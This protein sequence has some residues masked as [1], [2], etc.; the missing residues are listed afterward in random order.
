MFSPC[1]GDDH[2]TESNRPIEWGLAPEVS[3][4]ELISEESDD[5]ASL[6]REE[7]EQRAAVVHSDLLAVQRDIAAVIWSLQSQGQRVEF[8][9]DLDPR[10]VLGVTLVFAPPSQRGPAQSMPTTSRGRGG[11]EFR[12]PGAAST[13]PAHEGAEGTV[14]IPAFRA[15]PTPTAPTSHAGRRAGRG[16]FSPA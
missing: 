4:D 1:V 7:R 3:Q 10:A 13:I 11:D 15:T 8:T 14:V 12:A 6:T 16:P 5:P 9:T 2:G